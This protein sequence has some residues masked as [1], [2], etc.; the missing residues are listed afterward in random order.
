MEGFRVKVMTVPGWSVSKVRH[1]SNWEQQMS[2]AE[3][4]ESARRLRADERLALIEQLIDS[5]DEPD[6]AI[7]AA[8]QSEAEDRLAALKRGELTSLPMQGLLEKIRSA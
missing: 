7:Q 8:W 6:L 1:Q 5:L 4:L 2:N 3:I